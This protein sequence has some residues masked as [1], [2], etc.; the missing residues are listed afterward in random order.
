M[1]AKSLAEVNIL[2]PDRVELL[3]ESSYTFP[4]FTTKHQKRPGR[5]FDFGRF[6]MVKPVATVMPIHRVTGPEPVDE[7]HFERQA[8]RGGKASNGEAGL[9]RVGG[10]H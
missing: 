4:S 8:E 5:L 3:V 9:R 1:V 7:Q 10:V 6:F 2:E